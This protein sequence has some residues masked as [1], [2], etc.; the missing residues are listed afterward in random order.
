MAT[1]IPCIKHA[2]KNAPYEALELKI[3]CNNWPDQFPYSPIVKC[4]LWH[5]GNTLFIIFDVE[6]KFIAAKAEKDND[7]VCRDSCV[8]LFISF[9]PDGYY[10]IEANCGGKI[11]MSH[12]KGRKTDVEYATP[13]VL[14]QIKRFPSLGEA[15]FENRAADGTWQLVLSIPVSSF[16]KH[17]F[18]SFKGLNATGNIYKCGDDLPLPHYLSLF[19]ITTDTPDFHRPEFFQPIHFS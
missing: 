15:P 14:S 11:L 13:E 19:P 2:S 12:R 9:G 17:E 1:T 5:N 4:R 16:F 6:E 8:E 10:N 7:K 18:K 3:S